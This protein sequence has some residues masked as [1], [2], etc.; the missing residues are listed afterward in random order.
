MLTKIFEA[1]RN[2]LVNSVVS[3][4][5]PVQNES[6]NIISNWSY[7]LDVNPSPSTEIKES[8]IRQSCL[9]ISDYNGLDDFEDNGILE[10]QS[11]IKIIS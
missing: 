8:Q 3:Q 6:N 1:S 4:R 9:D 7:Y 5:S 10:I 2:A 11:N